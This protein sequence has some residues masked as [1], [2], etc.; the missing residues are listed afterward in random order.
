MRFFRVLSLGIKQGV[1]KIDKLN[2]SFSIHFYPNLP[3]MS[4]IENYTKFPKVFIISHL[5]M[6]I[7]AKQ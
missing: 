3:I 6:I 2:N 1:S 7:W 5:R 4:N